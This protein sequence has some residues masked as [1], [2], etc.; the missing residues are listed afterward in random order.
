MQSHFNF[1]FLSTLNSISNPGEWWGGI[2]VFN[3]QKQNTRSPRLCV[4][5]L[6]ATVLFLRLDNLFKFTDS[7]FCQFK[8]AIEPLAV[9]FYFNCCIFSIIIPVFTDIYPLLTFCTWVGTLIILF[10]FFQFFGHNFSSL[11]I[12][13]IDLKFSLVSPPFRIPEGQFSL[14]LFSCI[15][16]ILSYFSACLFHVETGCLKYYKMT[17]LQIIFHTPWG[18][19][20][21]LSVLLLLLLLLVQ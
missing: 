3:K 1:L 11:N 19:Q 12:F 4:F 21:L 8:S 14:L 20:A 17:I 18:L 13:I 10:F 5:L 9:N 2:K 15:Q 7:F 16:A 6:F